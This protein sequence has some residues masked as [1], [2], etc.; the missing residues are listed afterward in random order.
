MNSSMYT[1]RLLANNRD[2]PSLCLKLVASKL[3][4]WLYSFRRSKR[5][6]ETDRPEKIFMRFRKR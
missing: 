6:S 2:D 3:S 1:G 5:G 4:I